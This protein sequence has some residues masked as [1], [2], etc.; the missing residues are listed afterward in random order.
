M[1]IL[2]KVVDSN[3]KLLPASERSGGRAPGASAAQPIAMLRRRQL[4]IVQQLL[5]SCVHDLNLG[6]AVTGESR[7][8]QSMLSS[9]S[10]ATSHHLRAASVACISLH[11]CVS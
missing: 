6:A 1:Y 9:S 8:S 2:L 11:A 4:L 7:K 10:L 3:L 5:S